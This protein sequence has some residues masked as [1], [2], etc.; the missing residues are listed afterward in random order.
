[1]VQ[2]GKSLKTKKNLSK[3][4]QNGKTVNLMKGEIAG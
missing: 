4:E 3:L 1:M 2:F